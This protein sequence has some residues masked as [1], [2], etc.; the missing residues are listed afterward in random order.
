MTFI[1]SV[2]N[3]LWSFMTQHPIVSLLVL[4]LGA[5][6]FRSLFWKRASATKKSDKI[7]KPEKVRVPNAIYEIRINGPIMTTKGGMPNM[8][9]AFTIGSSVG[10]LLNEVAANEKIAGVIL[11]WNT[12]GGTPVGAEYIRQG[13]LACKAAG[14]KVVSHGLDLVASGGVWGISASDFVSAEHE[15]LYGSIG[16][17][18]PQLLHYEDVSTLGNGL[19]GQTVTGRIS[20]DVLYAG[21]GKAF[22]SPFIRP[23]KEE[24]A[25]FKAVL[26]CTYARF[27]AVVSEGRSIPAEVLE[28]LGARVINAAQ[29][30]TLGLIDEVMHAGQVRGKMVALLGKAE[31]ECAFVKAPEGPQGLLGKLMGVTVSSTNATVHSMVRAELHSTAALVIL[32]SYMHGV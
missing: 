27:C 1:S 21:K 19:F 17:I 32:P 24:I 4:A 30:K 12:P 2:W 23:D 15:T 8:G 3:T 9:G 28:G 13:I 11:Y 31:K 5:L 29:A 7:L 26:D 18:G 25:N 6:L 16:V 10:A 22:G 14:K 20:A